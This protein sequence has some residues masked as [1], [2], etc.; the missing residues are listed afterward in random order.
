MHV[1][2]ECVNINKLKYVSLKIEEIAAYL[3]H[4]TEVI[5]EVVIGMHRRHIIQNRL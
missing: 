1:Y 5:N 3:E 2:K 4:T